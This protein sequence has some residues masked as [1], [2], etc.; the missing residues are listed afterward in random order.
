M[1][2]ST[3]LKSMQYSTWLNCDDVISEVKDL[4]NC[5]RGSIVIQDY[6]CCLSLQTIQEKS[7]M[8]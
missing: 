1:Q 7:C 5:V 2:Y 3:W 8:N 6:A 4:K